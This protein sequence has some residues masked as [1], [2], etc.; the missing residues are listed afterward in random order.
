M[1]LPVSELNAEQQKEGS[2]AASLSEIARDGYPSLAGLMHSSSDIAIFRR[3]G[4]LNMLHLLRLQAELQHMEF[5]LQKIREE[6]AMSNDPIRECYAKDFAAMRDN[7]EIGDSEQYEQ[8]VKIG[9]K[10]QEYI[11]F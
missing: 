8:L 6:D 3:F 7:E 1:S 5:E 4:E 2:T 11:M 9:T 10:L